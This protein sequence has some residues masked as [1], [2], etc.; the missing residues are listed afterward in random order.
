MLNWWWCVMW[1]VGF[2]RL[3]CKLTANDTTKKDKNLRNIVGPWAPVICTNFLCLSLSLSHWHRFYLP[4]CTNGLVFSNE[5]SIEQVTV[6]SLPI[7][8]GVLPSSGDM[9]RSHIPD[10][11]KLRSACR[12]TFDSHFI[13]SVTVIREVNLA[14]PADGDFQ[15]HNPYYMIGAT[16]SCLGYYRKHKFIY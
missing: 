8:R 6:A 2:K 3:I 9:L 14:S 10:V 4:A 11:W 1:L 15:F 7:S 12:T 16:E 5:L 13:W